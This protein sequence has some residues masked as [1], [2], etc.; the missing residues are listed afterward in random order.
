[1]SSQFLKPKKEIQPRNLEHVILKL[2]A[3]HTDTF[4]TKIDNVP[5]NW[6]GGPEIVYPLMV[7]LIQLTLKPAPSISLGGTHFRPEDRVWYLSDL[8]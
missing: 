2:I 4:V 7:F 6:S 3:A 8:I 5:A 1:M